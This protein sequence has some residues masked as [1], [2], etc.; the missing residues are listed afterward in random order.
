VAT[1]YF[2]GPEL[3]LD[4]KNYD[5]SLDMWSLGCLMAGIIFMRN[6]FFKGKD[7]HDQLK[8]I[9]KVL[10]GDKFRIY[11]QK[12]FGGSSYDSDS[13]SDS[14]PDSDSNSNSDSNSDSCEDPYLNFYNYNGKSWNYFI[15]NDNEHLCSPEAIDLL[16]KFLRFDHR[17]RILPTEALQHPYFDNV[18]Q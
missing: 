2:K 6:P 7:D 11:R 1:R 12:L 3:L 9:V 15:D 17:E 8:K 5:Y 13:D 14:D 16:D 4:Y 18:R 10:G